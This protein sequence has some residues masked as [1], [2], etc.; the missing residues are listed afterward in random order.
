MMQIFF[1]KPPTVLA[2]TMC[3]QLKVGHIVRIQYAL[4]ADF[5][6]L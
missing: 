3:I 1:F 4:D 5:E 2:N 6:G